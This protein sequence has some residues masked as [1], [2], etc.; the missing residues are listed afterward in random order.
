[1][2]AKGFTLMELTISLCLIVL[3]LTAFV[4]V[5]AGGRQSATRAI[6]LSNLK[7]LGVA[8]QL[9]SHDHDGLFPPDLA[10]LDPYARNR[11]VFRCPVAARDRTRAVQFTT[12]YLYR[13]G[14]RNDDPADEAVAADDEPRHDRGANILTV[15]G[16]A[17]WRPASRWQLFVEQ[18]ERSDEACED[19]P[20]L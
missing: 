7:N 1:M 15:D 18:V 17:R 14:L 10:A 4:L 16:A 20:S 13:P 12:D 8:L 6:C 5:Y 9:Y 3:A 2:K 11:D 19:E